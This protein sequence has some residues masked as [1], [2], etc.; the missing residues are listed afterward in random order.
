MRGMKG[1]TLIELMIV[2]AIIA[3][4]ASIALPA[5]RT[6]MSKAQ[7]GAA[8]ADIRPGK[9]TVEQVAQERSDASAVDAN[10]IGLYATQRC[11]TISAALTDAG[12][13]TIACTVRGNSGVNG[14][15]L[16][17]QRST[18]GVWT[19]DASAFDENIRPSGC[20]GN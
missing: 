15:V 19:C 2:V 8:L 16:V 6:Q 1:F 17:L 18:D 11:P 10:Y 14:K 9:T 5:Y 20:V 4:L 13:G 7:L 3:V 12:V